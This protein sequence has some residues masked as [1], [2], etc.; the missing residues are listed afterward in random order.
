VHGTAE[1][2]YLALWNRGP[3]ERLEISGDAS[4]MELW[5]RTA[6]IV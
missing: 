1:E 4:I 6:A 5:R 2:L 3:Y